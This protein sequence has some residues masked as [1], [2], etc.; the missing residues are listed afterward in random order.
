LPG[1]EGNLGEGWLVCMQ[2]IFVCSKRWR[3]SY[4]IFCMLNDLIYWL[5]RRRPRSLS[6]VP[7]VV[8]RP[9]LPGEPSGWDS[10][11]SHWFAHISGI[12]SFIDHR[13]DMNPSSIPAGPRECLVSLWV[14]CTSWHFTGVSLWNGVENVFVLSYRASVALIMKDSPNLSSASMTPILQNLFESHL[15]K[16]WVISWLS[17][18]AFKASLV[19]EALRMS[20]RIAHL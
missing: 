16:F 17:S 8:C 2:Q 4:L 10:I 14:V 19:T 18:A 1:F 20:C 15:W 3:L 11:V 5:S 6:P 13:V 12:Q 7:G 9:L